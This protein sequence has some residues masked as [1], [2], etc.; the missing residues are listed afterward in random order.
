VGR[1]WSKAV[2]QFNYNF[3]TKLTPH[4]VPV[5]GTCKKINTG[6]ALIKDL[7]DIVSLH[8]TQFSFI[9]FIMKHLMFRVDRVALAERRQFYENDILMG[10]VQND[11]LIFS[12]IVVYNI[13]IKKLSFEHLN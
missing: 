10:I 12:H 11:V 13:F 6:A 7:F 3:L 9:N 4:V 5:L 2:R 8:K 1:T